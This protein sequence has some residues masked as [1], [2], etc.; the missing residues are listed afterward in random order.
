MDWTDCAEKAKRHQYLTAVKRSVQY[1][2][3]YRSAFQHSQASNLS[4][5]PSFGGRRVL[6]RTT[7][8]LGD[9]LRCDCGVT[10]ATL[11][12]GRGYQ[13]AFHFSADFRDPSSIARLDQRADKDIW[14]ACCLAPQLPALGI[15]VSNALLI[16]LP[17]LLVLLVV[18]DLVGRQT[19]PATWVSHT[20]AELAFG[21]RSP[22]P[23]SRAFYLLVATSDGKIRGGLPIF[24]K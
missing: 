24:F 8:K 19:A 5:P 16:M 18:G 4:L 23:R 11:R 6:Q 15:G 9:V 22:V 7:P 3:L 13:N 12:P 1:R 17:Y 14:P 20:G 21:R 10:A 2:M